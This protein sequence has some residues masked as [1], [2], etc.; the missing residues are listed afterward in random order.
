MNQCIV[1]LVNKYEYF[2]VLTTSDAVVND[3]VRRLS[4]AIH[5]IGLF[6]LS[7]RQ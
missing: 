4:I 5:L 7:P 6:S 2:F 1:M 3:L